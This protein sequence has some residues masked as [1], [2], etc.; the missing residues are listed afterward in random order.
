[1]E[2]MKTETPSV[3]VSA[4]TERASALPGSTPEKGGD[5]QD[6][7]SALFP[8]NSSVPP[9]GAFM[10]EDHRYYFNGQG[11]YPSVTTYLKILDKPAVY[12]WAKR[13]VAEFAVKQIV[14]L[15]NRIG[16]QGP[17]EAAKWLASLPEYQRDTAGKLGTGVHLLADMVSRASESDA[18]TFQV[19]PE[20]LPFLMGFKSFLSVYGAENIVSSEKMV[21][22][23]QD[24]YAGTFDLLMR[25]PECLSRTDAVPDCAV[26][27]L[28]L[29]DLKTSKGYYPEYAL[30]LAAY[31]NAEGIILP[32][33]PNLYTLPPV[34]RAGV[35]HLRPDQYPD[36]G[37]RLIEYPITNRDYV[38]FLACVELW[39][40]K[41]EGRFSK[42][43]LK[44]VV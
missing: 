41:A 36:T 4:A 43:N 34:Q 30:Q 8:V 15:Q 28:W 16:I 9:V 25:L 39:Q 3:S 11:P 14:E 20:V 12:Q 19:S 38:A 27:E 2:A 31:A 24:G 40:W 5:G 13:T 35:L 7:A 23:R 33:D 26:R 22:S 21:L 1:M 42:K 32:G 6:T 44:V 17:E 10:T 29:L 37:W 18:E